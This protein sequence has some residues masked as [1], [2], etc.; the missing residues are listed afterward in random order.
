M[1]KTSIP[2]FWDIGPHEPLLVEATWNEFVQKVGGKLVSELLLKS[3]DFDNADYFFESAGVVA[4]LKEIETEFS[5]AKAFH[6]G[7]DG[8]M[9]RLIVENPDWKPM[10]LGGNS[11]YP[12][13]FYPEFVRLFRPPV[14]RVLKKENRQIRETKKYLGKSTPTGVLLF[15]ND[16]FT[17]LGPDLVLALA[18]N[19][20][21]NSYSSIDCFVYLTV[22]RYVEIKG[23]NVPRLI[24]APTY[25]DRADDSLHLFINNLGRKWL[26]FIETKIGSFTISEEIEDHDIIQGSK[27]IIVLPEN[28][29]G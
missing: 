15:V 14:S 9:K 22:N 2:G 16:G 21:T 17:T 18:C 13:W 5:R 19:L 29:H 1:T 23:S 7:F 28:Y 12:K 8:L 3:P 10:L 11:E 4:E 24:W 25:S 26:K 20:L 27:A 6:N